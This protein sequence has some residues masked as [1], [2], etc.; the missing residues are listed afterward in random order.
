MAQKLIEKAAYLFE[1][2]KPFVLY[3]KPHED[4]LQLMMQHDSLLRSV[5]DYSE[6]GFI[7]APFD[8]AQSPL[9]IKADKLE[10][11]PIMFTQK[12]EISQGAEFIQDSNAQEEYEKLVKTAIEEISKGVMNKVVLSRRF[13]IPYESIPLKAFQ[14]LLT[15]YSNALAYLWYHPEIGCWLGASP[16]LFLSMSGNQLLTYSLAGTQAYAEDKEPDWGNKEKEEQEIVTH[17][18]I[19]KFSDLGLQP[20][21]TEAHSSRAGNLWHLRSEIRAKGKN[22]DL[23]SI[24]NSLHP[25]PAVCGI[26]KSMA[27]NFIQQNENYD[28]RFYTGYLGELNIAEPRGCSLFVNLRCMEWTGH[29]A[30]IYV[31]G[32]I[33][34][35]SS[36][37]SEWMET[38]FK[39]LTML[40]ALFNSDK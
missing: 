14:Y 3:R 35:K 4:Q 20:E 16:E 34:A 24:L 29:M 26:P 8:A 39:S 27:H 12:N 21:A 25:T 28:R 11:A 33:T 37:E 38:Q 30:H 23:R 15:Q 17:Y 13:S 36:P 1:N 18:I 6:S 19:Q 10:S 7:F 32:G 9:I 5:N 40:N 31:G 22:P 2:K